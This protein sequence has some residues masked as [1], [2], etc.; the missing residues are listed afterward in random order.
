M[1]TDYER[2]TGERRT[3]QTM[4]NQSSNN[5]FVENNAARDTGK[6]DHE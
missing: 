1:E 5:V 2:V 3:S 4:I 6:T